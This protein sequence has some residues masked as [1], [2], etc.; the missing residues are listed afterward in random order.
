VNDVCKSKPM[1]DFNTCQYEWGMYHIPVGYT[2]SKPAD[3]AQFQVDMKTRGS[4]QGC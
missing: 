1:R 3:I 2:E 4:S